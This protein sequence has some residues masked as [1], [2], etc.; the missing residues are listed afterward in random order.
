MSRL[1]LL[2][3]LVFLAGVRVLAPAAAQTVINLPPDPAPSETVGE[4]IINV[5]SGGELPDAFD[6]NDGATINVD[7][8][9]VGDYYDGYAGSVLNL[10]RGSVGVAPDVR[11]AAVINVFGGFL[12]STPRVYSG[13]VLNV[14]GGDGG[15]FIR[16]YDGAEVNIR[17]GEVGI[18]LEAYGNAVVNLEGGRLG[19]FA[20]LY[21]QAIINV[22]GGIIASGGGLPPGLGLYAH[23][24]TT[25]NI[26][27]G[28]GRL[29]IEENVTV[30][31]SG[32]HLGTLTVP[33]G[34]V[35]NYSGGD[36]NGNL[37][38]VGGGQ[39]L[40]S[41]GNAQGATVATG[42]VLDW[43]GGTIGDSVAFST[44]AV[45]TIQGDEFRLD[46]VPIAGLP[47]VGDSLA[48]N[49]P[50]GAILS[51]VLSD[52][53]PFAIVTSESASV[54]D[55]SLTLQR[56]GLPTF[57]A[58]VSIAEPSV[59]L[60][61]RSG[62]SMTVTTGGTLPRNTTV[63]PDG[64]LIVDGGSVGGNL[65][66]LAAEIQL[67][68]GT[69]DR[70]FDALPGTVLQISGGRIDFNAELFA[71][72]TLV[73][74]GGRI[75]GTFDGISNFVARTGSQVV[76]RGGLLGNRSTFHVGS[77]LS[78]EGSDFRIN[79]VA[80]EGLTTA[81]DS[82][83]IDPPGRELFTGIL[84][85]GTP[86]AFWK[87]DQLFGNVTLEYHA[88][89]ATAGEKFYASQGDFPLGIR[90]DQTLIVDAGSELP[91]GSIAGPGARLE[92]QGG[93]IGRYF[94]AV[95]AQLVA[96]SGEFLGRIDLLQ[97]S[98]LLVDGAAVRY[99]GGEGALNVVHDSTLTVR[100]GEIDSAIVVEEG[101]H[102]LIAGGV[103]WPGV[104][105]RSLTVRDGGSAE[106]VDGELGNGLNVMSGGRLT[107][108]GGSIG[109]SVRGGGIALRA[110]AGSEVLMTGGRVQVTP[111][112][113]FDGSQVTISGGTIETNL[114][115]QAG[116]AVELTGGTLNDLLVQ[117][118]LT[119]SG[120]KRT[121]ET[122]IYDP[123]EVQVLGVSFLLDGQEVAG[124]DGLD[125]TL[126]LT[127]RGGQLLEY[128]LPN[129][130]WQ[131]LKLNESNSADADF[132]APAAKLWLTRAAFRGD[133][134]LD[135]DVDGADF[136]RLQRTGEPLLGWQQTYGLTP[137]PMPAPAAI[138]EPTTALL[139]ALPLLFSAIARPLRER[140]H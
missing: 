28:G 131:K 49:V 104:I 83:T 9:K 58:N 37:A 105:D 119:I 38:P 21:D 94:E 1:R 17:G 67:L 23:P 138:P 78:L 88:P 103:L 112:V 22:R 41:G 136:L 57:E 74:T 54:A 7:G 128:L 18:N 55:G 46:N 134:D 139:L 27:S 92:L 86:F 11:D 95:G 77:S 70:D 137:S 60:G 116:A 81:G 110:F 121:G 24:G 32:G 53:S 120:G 99:A 16:A 66:A 80:V 48:L 122:D 33:G 87:D 44:G 6:A 101:G 62:Q 64:V 91:A 13:G 135:D 111:V 10:Y 8:G 100:S 90:G 106:I 50:A 126:L 34:S 82:T 97:S 107:I 140:L 56:S 29:D 76:M 26:E 113:A 31:M 12:G 65:E 102:A 43:S 42:G 127:E 63:A 14:E 89:P 123:A 130:S 132:V 3:L 124:L 30:N 129:G 20:D 133:A 39:V 71:G 25:V 108:S 96:T 117:G 15:D 84:A 35:M 52:G 114:E 61:V 69:I 109:R 45:V 19:P 68:S 47:G 40:M 85:D 115:V 2:R 36:M 72:S 51:G 125:D 73:Q 93:T 59:L 118:L 79:G 4:T 98:S 75:G 5:L